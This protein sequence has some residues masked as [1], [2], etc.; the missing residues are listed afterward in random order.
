MEGAY[1][2]RAGGVRAGVSISVIHYYLTVSLPPSCSPFFWH[3]QNPRPPVRV[4]SDGL[5]LPFV[6]GLLFL[7]LSASPL[8]SFVL[9]TDSMSA[10]DFEAEDRGTRDEAEGGD[11]T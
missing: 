9:W 8:F 6:V 7:F 2:F 4:L 5:L 10:A 11:R 3:R 1:V